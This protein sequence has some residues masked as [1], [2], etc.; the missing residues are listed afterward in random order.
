MKLST[1]N[2]GSPFIPSGHWTRKGLQ[3]QWDKAT[4]EAR[5]APV[6]IVNEVDDEEVP[7]VPKDFQY[8]EH[9]YDWGEYAPDPSFLIGCE[10]VG[11]CSAGVEG[12]C[13]GHIDSDPGDLIG[14]WYDKRVR[15][16]CEPDFNVTSLTSG[17]GYVPPWYYLHA[18]QGMQ[19][20]K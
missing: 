4:R 8:L 3:A 18:A 20:S 10:C 11:N 1:E 15:S 14:F 12:C 7:G 9:G 2:T 13:I 19:H 16:P 6:T 5:S 17:L